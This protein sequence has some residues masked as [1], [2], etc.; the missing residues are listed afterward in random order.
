METGHDILFHWVA[1]MVMLGLELTNQLPFNVRY[2]I[3]KR[4]WFRAL[5]KVIFAIF[6]LT[7]KDKDDLSETLGVF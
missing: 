1:K 4:T 3:L 5:K 6:F 2:F 7:R